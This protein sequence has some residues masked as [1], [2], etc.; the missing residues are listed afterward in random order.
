M[1]KMV[2]RVLGEAGVTAVLVTHDQAE[3]LSFADQIAVLD[4]GR[5]MQAGTP[6]E[7]YMKPRDPVTAAFLGDAILLPAE[8][9]DGVAICVL[10]H[11][12]AETGPRRGAATVMLRPE[13]LRVTIEPGGPAGVAGTVTDVAFGGAVSGIA[14]AL[15]GP[16]GVEPLRVKVPGNELPPPGARVRV[17][18]MG[19]AHIVG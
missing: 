1:R 18:V 4:R 7:I 14:I 17:T 10:G 3:A 6:R 5:L 13:Q 15:D 19:L 16:A 8:L 2:A 9:A 12:L 11:V